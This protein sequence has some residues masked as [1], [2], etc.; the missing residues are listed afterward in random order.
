MIKHCVI[1]GAAFEA[2][3]TSKKITCSKAC[4]TVRKAQ[5]HL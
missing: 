1:C 5:S 2:Q 4:S 3:P